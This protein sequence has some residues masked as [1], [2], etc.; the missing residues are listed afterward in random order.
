MIGW[1][2][3]TSANGESRLINT[4]VYIVIREI[5]MKDEQGRI[6]CTNHEAAADF[7]FIRCFSWS[8]ER[9]PTITT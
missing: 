3:H 1:T 2:T 7:I 6:S 4:S 9:S 5:A 8:P